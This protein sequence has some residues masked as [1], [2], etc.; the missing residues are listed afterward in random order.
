MAGHVNNS[1]ASNGPGARAL[2]LGREIWQTEVDCQ[3]PRDLQTVSNEFITAVAKSISPN[4]SD[5]EAGSSDNAGNSD[6][7]IEHT[8]G[9]EALVMSNES[10]KQLK[11]VIA[12]EYASEDVFN[13]AL[14][15][16][17]R[18][19]LK[20]YERKTKHS[21]FI[22]IKNSCMDDADDEGGEYAIGFAREVR[23]GL[24][25][26]E[27]IPGKR[28]SASDST[29]SGLRSQFKTDHLV[30]LFRRNNPDKWSDDACD[31][32]IPIDCFSVVELKMSDTICD[33]FQ[34]DGEKRIIP[35][36][37]LQDGHGPLGQVILYTIGC[38]HLYLA[39]RG[40]L[41]E[42]PRLPLAIV[43]AKREK[44]EREKSEE[45]LS[46]ESKKQKILEQVQWVSGQ[47]HVPKACGGRFLYSVKDFGN[48]DD[49][50]SVE[51]ALSLY[52]DTMLFGWKV[53]VQ[54]RDELVN[55]ELSPALPAS[56]RY[57]MLDGKRLTPTCCAS[58][59]RGANPI[60]GVIRRAINQ[61]DC[62]RA[63]LTSKRLRMPL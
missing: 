25:L 14:F 6:Q 21:N 11:K 19:S 34:R 56:G 27:K 44:S 50:L 9:K 63:S 43:A 30:C 12:N 7:R 8:G 41:D 4:I 16:K 36:F 35:S 61:G 62:F 5:N 17:L 51:N 60:P 59:I 26:F 15:E 29:S 45:L 46:P 18:Q 47:L 1:L 38:V 28:L 58:P 52:I 55:K 3:P 2:L 23:A 42:E 10:L 53:A 13:K 31:D 40:K 39:R 20:G 54:V 37:K 48:F 22:L 33:T 57:L 24:G 49:E 32:W